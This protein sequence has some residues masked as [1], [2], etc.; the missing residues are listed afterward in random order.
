MNVSKSQSVVS[1]VDER[2]REGD[3]R[4]AMR[5]IY[6]F[7]LDCLL[8]GDTR[9]ITRLMQLLPVERLPISVVLAPLC[10]TAFVANIIAGRDVYLRRV[11]DRLDVLGRK[12]I[13]AR[14]SELTSWPQ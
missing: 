6:R 10:S 14:L 12:D 11:S 13:A 5:A 3:E 9:A 7:V 4:T 2:L 1:A 8:S